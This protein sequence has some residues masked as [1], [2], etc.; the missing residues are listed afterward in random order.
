MDANI[1]EIEKYILKRKFDINI[2]P[3]IVKIKTFILRTKYEKYGK[4]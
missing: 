1:K 4:L 3:D 2:T